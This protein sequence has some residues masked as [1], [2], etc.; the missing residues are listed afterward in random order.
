[1]C[2]Q[3]NA[4]Q[5]GK[6]ERT[7]SFHSW[8]QKPPIRPGPGPEASSSPA[9]GFAASHDTSAHPRHSWVAAIERLLGG[10]TEPVR[11]KL[12]PDQVPGRV[13]A[14]APNWE[15]RPVHYRLPQNGDACGA[16]T[17]T[18]YWCGDPEKLALVANIAE[19][20]GKP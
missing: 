14:E 3:S 20:S 2:R 12:P 17:T 10:G 16:G 11:V 7:M 15:E 13:I 6:G 9:T 18:R 19:P 1:M 4:D 5:P 8:L